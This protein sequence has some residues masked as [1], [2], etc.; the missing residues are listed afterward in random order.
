MA[1]EWQEGFRVLSGQ[2]MLCHG[3]SSNCW[4]DIYDIMDSIFLEH[5][6]AAARCD[7]STLELFG[8]HPTVGI[9]RVE[10]CG[11]L[12][13]AGLKVI[14]VG[15]DAIRYASGLVYRRVPIVPA[16]PVWGAASKRRGDLGRRKP[17]PAGAERGFL[18]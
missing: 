13:F 9:A 6:E 7:W 15:R 3:F 11:A 4:A 10:W 17:R 16:V 8:V 5:A 1:Q 12:S 14:E 2:Q 18:S